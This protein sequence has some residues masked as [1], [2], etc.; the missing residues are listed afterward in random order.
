MKTLE[1]EN[2]T[3]E[4]FWAEVRTYQTQ[5][6]E[7]RWGQAAFNVLYTHR[8]DLSE[9]IRAT[10]LDPFHLRNLQDNRWHNFLEFLE[11]NW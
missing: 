6:P 5:N 4:E 10:D 8:R 1:K 3:E 7:Q 2:I 11:E 9:Q